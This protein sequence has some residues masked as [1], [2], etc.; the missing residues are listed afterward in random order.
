MLDI[1]KEATLVFAIMYGICAVILGIM[2][3]SGWILEQLESRFGRNNFFIEMTAVSCI[4]YI[5]ILIFC[6]I[7]HKAIGG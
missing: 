4:G 3:F 7:R 1:F 2:F 6:I 5:L